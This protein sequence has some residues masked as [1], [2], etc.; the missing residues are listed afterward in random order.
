MSRIAF[1]R[2]CGTSTFMSAIRL[3]FAPPQSLIVVEST[4]LFRLV[5]ARREFLTTTADRRRIHVALSSRYRPER[6]FDEHSP[7]VEVL[8]DEIT[9]LA[10][11]KSF[12]HHNLERHNSH[13]NSIVTAGLAR[14][15]G[16][17]INSK[18]LP[19]TM[20]FTTIATLPCAA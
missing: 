17:S 16:N 19:S 12:D 14:K 11:G 4:T 2:R 1:R 13:L 6:V 3:P 9:P 18:T 20:P 7:P 8:S 5:T 15:A 10:P